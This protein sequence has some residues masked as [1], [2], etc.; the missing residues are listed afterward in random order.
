MI[1]KF[2]LLC[3][4][5]AM[6]GSTFADEPGSAPNP[7]SECG[8]GA[9]IFGDVGWAAATSNVIWDL[10][11]TAVVSAI[12]SPETCNAKKEETA[13]LI[14]ETL[15]KLEQ[16]LANGEGEHLAALQQTVSCNESF[17]TQFN[18]DLRSLYAVSMAEPEA[19]G[20]LTAEQRASVMYANVKSIVDSNSS[21]CN[22][23]L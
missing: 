9:A 5:L 4:F 6:S 1:K 18:T 7:F 3:G 14:L 16:D 20:S 19:Y 12:S 10:G 21:S 2:V 8:I 17:E 15:P 11:I 23:T 22:V 13:R